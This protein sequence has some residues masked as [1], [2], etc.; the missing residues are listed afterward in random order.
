MESEAVPFTFPID[1]G[2]GGEEVRQAPMAYV[3]DLV[4]KVVQLLDQNDK[5]THM[6]TNEWVIS[7]IIHRVGRL[8]KG[9][10]F[11]PS[12]EIWVKLG[13]DKGGSTMKVSFQILNCPNPNSPTNTCVFVAYEGPDTKTNLH[14]AL[15]RYKSQIQELQNLKWR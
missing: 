12:D 6:H 1:G 5:Y 8:N 7:L 13:G 14:V 4:K 9:H 10:K 2:K 11:I 15:D 3:P